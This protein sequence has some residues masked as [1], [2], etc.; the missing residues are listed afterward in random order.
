MEVARERLFEVYLKKYHSNN[1]HRFFGRI[2]NKNKKS[3]HKRLPLF[4]LKS[5]PS[6]EPKECNQYVNK[7]LDKGLYIMPII[8]GDMSLLIYRFGEIGYRTIGSV[9]TYHVRN[10][11][12]I[13]PITHGYI[14]ICDNGIFLIKSNN[15]K[16]INKIIY[17]V[18]NNLT[19]YGLETYPNPKYDYRTHY[20]QY[21]V[22][23]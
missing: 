13:N 18:T 20:Y 11:K 12:L 10:V 19:D 4:V 8:D 21:H 6:F 16:K 22:E 2:F 1:K 15:I 5:L 17:Q 3:Y 9:N 7:I 23:R 14:H